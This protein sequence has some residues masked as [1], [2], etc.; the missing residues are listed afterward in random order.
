MWHHDTL[1]S[2]KVEIGVG[3]IEL[4]AEGVVVSPSPYALDVLRRYGNVTGFTFSEETPVAQDTTSEGADAP[5]EA[6]PKR[7]RTARKAAKD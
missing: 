7:R 1:K 3:H 6:K 5:D 4:N 2:C